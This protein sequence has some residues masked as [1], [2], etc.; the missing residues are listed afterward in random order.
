MRANM[1]G[2]VIVV[3]RLEEYLAMSTK[4]KFTSSE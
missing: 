3:R 2:T 4:V 1:G